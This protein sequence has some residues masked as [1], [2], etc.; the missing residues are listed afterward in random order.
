[1]SAF[2]L[3]LLVT[4]LYTPLSEATAQA[5]V[6]DLSEDRIDITTGFTGSD[7]LLFGATDGSGD[8]IVVVRGPSGRVVMRRKSRVAGI[9]VNRDSAELRDVPSF[10]YVAASA[11]PSDILPVAVLQAE[12][13]GSEHLRLETID[14]LAPAEAAAFG[15]ALIRN[16]Q[17]DLLFYD[18][19]GAVEFVGDRLFR[20]RVAFPANVSTGVYG[21]D[22]YQVVDGIIASKTTT[23]LRIRKAGF[24]AEVFDFAQTSP[25]LYGLIAIVIALV[26]GWLAGYVFRKV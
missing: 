4:L 11:P 24:E 18:A 23:P 14:G 22:V 8:V 5:L 6:A 21:V 1:M 12:R 20:A 26:A 13:I 15:A 2:R 17:R 3:V 16:K 19:L 7:V 25:A 10:Y 9:W